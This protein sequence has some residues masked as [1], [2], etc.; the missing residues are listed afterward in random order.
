MKR[1]N[2]I[3]ELYNYFD[4]AHRLFYLKNKLS[5]SVEEQNEVQSLQEKINNYENKRGYNQ[6][7]VYGV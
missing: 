4:C 1:A 3:E 2:F 7:S 5:K 6:L